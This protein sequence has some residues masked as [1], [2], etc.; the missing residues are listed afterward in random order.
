MS[1]RD[2]WSSVSVRIEGDRE[3]LQSLSPALLSS[4]TFSRAGTV[5]SVPVSEANEAALQQ[6]LD[7]LHRFL[8]THE[9][10]LADLPAGCS[11]DAFVGWSPAAPQESLTLG[12]PLLSLLS[13]LGAELIFDTYSD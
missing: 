10:D 2:G 3:R 8:Y 9:Q 6:R 11:L 12:K 7:E 13:R 5:L 1:H 4:G